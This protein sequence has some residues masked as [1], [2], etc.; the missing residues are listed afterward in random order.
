MVEVSNG[1]MD[2]DQMVEAGGLAL[3]GEYATAAESQ[4]YALVVLAMNLDCWIKMEAG[5]QRFMLYADP[6]F[7]VAIGDEF[8]LYDVERQEVVENVDLPLFKSGAE[9]AFLWVI[10]L[11]VVFAMQGEDAG[12][13][14][15]Y[16]NSS[17][18]LFD[19]GEWWRPFTSLF[20][21]GDFNH[22]IG[23]I[24]FGVIF[25]VL[26]AHSVGP[27]LGWVLILA[28]G[29]IGNILTAGIHY[30]DPFQSLGA[31]TATFGALGML[32][33][34]GAYVA[35]RSRSY[36]KLGTVLVPIGAGV[37]LLG[38]LGVGG[39]RTDVLGHVMGFAAGSVLG[40]VAT[41]FQMRRPR[42]AEFPLRAA[43]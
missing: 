25:C 6:A 23:N 29:T 3:V 38:W 13:S 43:H 42:G 39:E 28:S 35:W 19:G 40:L 36:R 21:H 11:L 7:A 27:V 9:L 32:V 33:G 34:V 1:M 22:M 8:A 18:A 24:C 14:D 26:V 15:R 2:T 31:S 16:C 30:P 41:W 4:E 12:F 5:G 37:V 10:A 17:L 20:L